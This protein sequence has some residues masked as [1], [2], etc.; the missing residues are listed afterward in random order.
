MGRSSS[1]IDRSNKE[2]EFWDGT[3]NPA[4]ATSGEDMSELGSNL[5]SGAGREGGQPAPA[6]LPL[7]FT[8]R[9]NNN[10]T[11]ISVRGSGAG[12]EEDRTVERGGAGELE[13]P[14]S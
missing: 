2:E 14:V 11:V 3:A 8:T 5:N 1:S 9:V 12:S 4:L 7:T 6:S 13:H 10:A